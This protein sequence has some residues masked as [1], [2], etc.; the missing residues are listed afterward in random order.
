MANRSTD[1]SFIDLEIHIAQRRNVGYPVN[2]TLDSQQNFRGNLSPDIVGQ[3][4][5]IDPTVNGQRLFDTLFADDALRDAW[6]QA[7]GKST[8]RRI[9]LWIDPDAVELHLLP[10]ELLWGDNTMLSANGSTP[11]SRYLPSSK[12]WGG[13]VEERP[14]RVLAVISNPDDL[15]EYNLPK[16]N[17]EKEREIL[18]RAFSELDEREIQVEFLDAPV[19]M[20]RLEVAL[21]KGYHILHF[22]GH[23]IF[24]KDQ[25]VASLYMQNEE[26]NTETVSDQS[27]A[28]MLSR[29]QVQPRLVFLAA[30]QSAARSTTDTFLGLGPKLVEAGMPAVVAMQE[31]VTV[32]TAR[33]LSQVFYQRLVEHGIVDC[34]IN[35][36][37]SVLL[38]AG[39]P[40][41]TVPVL[42]MR[43]KDG[44]LWQFNAKDSNMRPIVD[45][46]VV[47]GILLA[48]LLYL[49]LAKMLGWQPFLNWQQVPDSPRESLSVLTVAGEQMY[50]GSYDYGIARSDTQGNWSDWLREGL[51]T[52]ET[53]GILIDPESNVPVIEALKI[54]PEPLTQT[55]A[56][57]RDYGLFYL[58]DGNNK[59]M[60]IGAG[61]VPTSTQHLDVKDQIIL[62]A[63][64]QGE[65]FGSQ[66]GGQTWQ[67]LSGENGLPAGTWTAVRFD[68][69]GVPY[70]GGENGLYSGAGI[71]PWKWSKV[72]TQPVR[73][74]E[75]GMDQ[76]L[77]VACGWPR[78]IYAACYTPELGWTPLIDLGGE[79]SVD[80][81]ITALATHPEDPNRFYIGTIKYVYEL[82][83]NGRK[84]NL[85]SSGD[86]VSGLAVLPTTEDRY[87]LIQ[88]NW[89]GLYQRTIK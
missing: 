61:Q 39:R 82:T 22:V 11:F 46:I 83:C 38:T 69:A 84:R 42:F 55:Y 50:V 9:R 40:D 28:D 29:Q 85:G 62:I 65:V 47:G 14:I 7:L 25:Q 8:Q 4:L 27:F 12:P 10:W 6:N 88:T 78:A 86:G 64:E 63:T 35:E 18:E 81:I 79:Q 74:I 26:G 33:K 58:Q 49:G 89:D 70:L 36:A 2:I 16:L 44:Q 31:S 3:V 80:N 57:V 24:S 51:P 68:P 13:V 30:C 73:Y 52:V 59:W 45:R 1:E 15:K 37:R 53:P 72:W 87:R 41:A 60:P 19:T 20:E 56:L 75:F 17:G 5:N 67:E 21:H 32:A 66:N 54:S 48:I 71:F 34:A 23:G 77:Y 43:L 76:R